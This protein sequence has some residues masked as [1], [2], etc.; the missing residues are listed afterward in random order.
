LSAIFWRALII[1]PEIGRDFHSSGIAAPL[2]LLGDAL[3][4]SA[5][6]GGDSTTPLQGGTAQRRSGPT[7]S[8]CRKEPDGRWILFRDAN[9]LKAV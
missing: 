5:F 4:E 6:S 1:V 3:P 9:M 2:F 8:V 7:L